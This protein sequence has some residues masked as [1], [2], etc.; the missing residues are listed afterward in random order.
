MR[1]GFLLALAA[2][3]LLAPPA[4]A[5]GGCPTGATC[6]IVTVPLDHTGATPGTLRI[7]Y[8]RVPATGT[9]TGTIVL[10]AGGPGQAAIPFTNSFTELLKALRPSY[11]F[12]Y[13]DQRGTG[14]SSAVQC[15]YS[16]VSCA[17]AL[18]P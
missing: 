16:A 6:G 2:A 12:V 5:A 1:K 18:G 17:D 11:D 13:V 4:K 9:R 15:D 10:L 7:A 8:S 3:L 14:G